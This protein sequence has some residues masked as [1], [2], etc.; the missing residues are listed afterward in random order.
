[1]TLVARARGSP[2]PEREA[3][4]QTEMQ[5]VTAHDDDHGKRI[6]YIRHTAAQ[7]CAANG[8]VDHLAP[9]L[10]EKLDASER[11]DL[12]WMP[13]A[14]AV[15]HGGPI[16]AQERLIARTVRVLAEPL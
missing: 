13:E 14:V 10:R 15:V 7:A 6:A 16:D 2:T 8:A 3:V 4:I 9:H 12:E 11:S 5:K 1:M